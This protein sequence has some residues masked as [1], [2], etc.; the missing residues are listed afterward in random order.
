MAD[1]IEVLPPQV[2]NQI[3]AGEAVQ[4]PAS[5][6]KELM[7]N[8]VDAGS[9]SVTVIIQDGGHTLVQVIDNGMGMTRGD[10][11][12]AFLRNAT[13][14]IR[15]ADDLFA[16]HTFGFR[17]EA[18]A[19]IAAVAEVEMK[20]C[21]RGE[22]IG[23][24][25]AISGGS[26]PEIEQISCGE[27]TNISV[28]NL[29][30]NIP[31]RRKFLKSPAY[32]SRLIL[33][34]FQRVALVNPDISFTLRSDNAKQP[35]SLE[36]GNLHQRI[37][38]LIGKA[39][40]NKLLPIDSDTPVVRISGYIGTPG[41]ARKSSSEQFFFV[42]GRYIRSSYLQKAV[43][44]GYNKLI[45][46]ETTPAFFIYIE[47]DPSR[48]D[49]NIHPTKTEIEFDDKQAIWQML[50]AA[51][52]QTLGRHNIVPTLD[53]ENQNPVDI[54]IYSQNEAR[55]GVKI[56]A[57]SS[58][59]NQSYNPF[60][61]YDRQEW[62]SPQSTSSSTSSFK[63]W[64]G[65]PEQAPFTEVIPENLL[66]AIVNERYDE[67]APPQ[68]PQSTQEQEEESAEELYTFSEAIS[69]ESEVENSTL[70]QGQLDMP[71]EQNL[72][73]MV[74]KNH[75]ILTITVDGI[76]LIDSRRAL[77]RIAYEEMLE[78]SA[79]HTSHTQ[80]LLHPYP[81]ELS[82][83]DH[84]LLMDHA[85]DL[86]A[87]G[88]EIGDMGGNCIALHGMPSDLS[89]QASPEQTLDSLLRQLKEM[90][91]SLEAGR[92]ERLAAAMS[93]S[94]LYPRK[95]PLTQQEAS[96]I[97]EKLFSLNEPN[98]TPDSLPIIEILS[99]KELEKRFKNRNP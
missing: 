74:Y 39:L 22:Q 14:K 5:I 2:A 54:P 60:K 43:V 38:A 6:V 70:Q 98:Y 37:V 71:V 44:A 88:F 27:G 1:I 30:F 26:E 34:E 23:T 90:G 76:L 97:V 86:G 28:R 61:S 50:N 73:V 42:N 68:T 56:T 57:P 24:R 12:R 40:G 75:Y 21:R 47:V 48:I 62:E 64:S 92:R 91:Q 67:I 33:A 45:S 96:V 29:F 78:S 51:V 95:A 16:L 10:S 32:E 41:T 36:A 69:M 80:M 13:S 11:V 3:A 52:K 4:R 85:T 7:E 15:K 99:D 18:L 94:Y 87:L 66:S 63:A 79:T 89:T 53:F 25:V 65:D 82:L 19:S 58:F 84:T 20:T 55:S 93:R 83:S 35:L 81:I 49:V 9:M 17:G 31:A 59:E 8:S 72:L 46:D 77:Q